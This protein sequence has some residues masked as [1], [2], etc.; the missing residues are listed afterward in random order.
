MTLGCRP[1]V[2]LESQSL[3]AIARLPWGSL[4]DLPLPSLLS[5]PAPSLLQAIHISSFTSSQGDCSTDVTNT[6]KQGR[7]Q[8]SAL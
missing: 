8:G 6:L 2:T 3:V 1:G 7:A 4:E 5:F